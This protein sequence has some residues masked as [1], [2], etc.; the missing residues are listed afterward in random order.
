VASNADFLAIAIVR[1]ISFPTSS[2][3]TTT[4]VNEGVSSVSTPARNRKPLVPKTDSTGIQ[5]INSP[6]GQ[7][8]YKTTFHNR[9]IATPA[10]IAEDVISETTGSPNTLFKLK[11]KERSLVD[12]SGEGIPETIGSDTLSKS[13]EHPVDDC[14]EG[15][16]L[17]YTI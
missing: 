7:S 1:N 5:Q 17:F 9:I 14:E 4:A 16:Y 10:T 6:T 13:Q 15:M 12:D 11:G 3:Q 2:K 8:V